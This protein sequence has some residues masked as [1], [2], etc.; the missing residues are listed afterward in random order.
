[1]HILNASRSILTGAI[2]STLHKC[3][4]CYI[5]RN[6]KITIYSIFSL[7]PTRLIKIQANMNTVSVPFNAF[8]ILKIPVDTNSG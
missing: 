1:M 2:S 8:L 4:Q 6:D 7:I 3:L 5:S